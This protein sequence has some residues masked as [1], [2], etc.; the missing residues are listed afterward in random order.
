MDHNLIFSRG[1]LQWQKW[2]A[3]VCRG[4]RGKRLEQQALVYAIVSD[5]ETKCVLKKKIDEV[6][7]K[8]IDL[9]SIKERIGP[10]FPSQGRYKEQD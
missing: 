7:A 9:G 6:N 8:K 4:N 1:E 10:T 3:R 5:L 2:C